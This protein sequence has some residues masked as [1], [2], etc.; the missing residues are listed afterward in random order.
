MPPIGVL[1]RSGS[2]RVPTLAATVSNRYSMQN[3]F[4][5]I[6]Q[7]GG[8][9]RGGDA[10]CSRT[11]GVA[12]PG[13]PIVVPHLIYGALDASF[14]VLLYVK[15]VRVKPVAPRRGLVRDQSC[16]MPGCSAMDDHL[17][18]ALVAEIRGLGASEADAEDCAQEALTEAWSRTSAGS[19]PDDTMTWL[20]TFARDKYAAC[21]TGRAQERA[22]GLVPP[23]ADDRL[24][25]GPEDQAVRQEHA[26]FLTALLRRLPRATQ[27]VC[28]LAG[29]G[30][31]RSTV[32]DELGLSARSVESHLTRAR[33][34]LRPH[35]PLGWLAIIAVAS[36]LRRALGPR[37]AAATAAA[38]VT[39]GVVLLPAA[40]E[41]S[42][43]AEH[44]IAAPAPVATSAPSSQRPPRPSVPTPDIGEPA[45]PVESV[46]TPRP[47]HPIALPEIDLPLP[48]PGA[49]LPTN[50]PSVPPAPSPSVGADQLTD[51]PGGAAGAVQAVPH[52]ID[53]LTGE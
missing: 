19:P 52:L 29:H 16:R 28:R 47:A 45:G 24:A 17:R 12:Y 6:T 36:Q 44:T 42:G 26:R 31:D 48:L 22:A 37:M 41:P 10:R 30:T 33:R 39:T 5:N 34:L 49:S 38:A 4:A 40:D 18:A 53:L 15:H 1:I 2:P 43:P 3:H 20:I 32:A 7:W 23:D 9:V 27:E 11:C 46:P 8:G 13:R 25:E 14:V 50:L 21:V 51:T 35:G